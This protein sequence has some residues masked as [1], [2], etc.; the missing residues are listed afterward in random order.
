MAAYIA[1]APFKSNWTAAAQS[2]FQMNQCNGTSNTAYQA[3]SSAKPF[4]TAP[5]IRK[6]TCHHTLFVNDLKGNDLFDGTFEKPLKTIQA[7]LS[8]TRALRTVHGSENILCMNPMSF[9]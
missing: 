3:P 2:A 7:A 6:E 5:E 1:P 4:M 9:V 8:L